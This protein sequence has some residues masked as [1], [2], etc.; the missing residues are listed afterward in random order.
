MK[1][2]WE[3]EAGEVAPEVRLDKVRMTCVVE[4]EHEL[5]LVLTKARDKGKTF[6]PFIQPAA[7]LTQEVVIVVHL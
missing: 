1:S 6:Q 7:D 5:V 2:L 4:L 3:S